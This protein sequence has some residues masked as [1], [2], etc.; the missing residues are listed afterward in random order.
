MIFQFSTEGDARWKI[1]NTISKLTEKKRK[2]NRLYYVTTRDVPNADVITEELSETY[3]KG[4]VIFP[5]KW[6]VSNAVQNQGTIN[7]YN[8]FVDS[9]YHEFNKPGTSFIVSNLD[10]DSRLFVFLRQQIEDQKDELKL[11]EV[12]ADTLILFALEDTDPDENRFKTKEQ[13]FDSVKNYVNF[14]L[15]NLDETLEHQLIALTRKPRKVHLHPKKGYCLPYETRLEI[16][17]RNLQDQN[18]IEDF[19]KETEAKIRKYLKD[20]DVTVKNLT[21]LINDTIHNIYYQQGL[22]FSNFIING[23]SKDVIEK[24]LQ[25]VIS[26][27]VDE[28]GVVTHNKEK[29]KTVLLMAIRDIVYNGTP[30]QTH[31]LKSLSNTYMMMFLLQWDPKLAIYFQALASKLTVFVCT[32][33]IIPAFSEYYLQSENKRHWNLLKGARKAGIRLYIDDSILNELTHHFKMLKYK[34]LNYFDSTEAVYLS[35]ENEILFIDEIMIRA[36]FYAKMRGSV[37]TYDDFIM[38]FLNPNLKTPRE[39]L[40]GYLKSEFGMEYLTNEAIG[41]NISEEEK[42]QLLNILKEKKDINKAKTDVNLILT[43]YKLREKKNEINSLGIFGYKTWWLSKDTSTYRAVIA[44]FGEEKYPV[45]CYIRPDF[46]YNYM[47]FM[48][49]KEEI[50][51][52]YQKIFPTLL[53]VNLSFHLPKDVTEVIQSSVAAHKDKS[54]AQVQRI[55]RQLS[56]KLKSDPALRNKRAVTLFLDDELNK[57]KSVA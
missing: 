33:I 5:L 43:I 57:L 23:E 40:L 39:D 14:D 54:P 55:L 7:A 29:I 18:L 37:R 21:G 9:Y 26:K 31:Y 48:P 28:S 6:F 56:D 17:A 45:S 2:F 46:I 22:E 51:D 42:L 12:L 20:V 8:T 36:Y 49:N 50:D 38:N 25:E 11:D 52:A 47:T 3:S 30:Q 1:I 35:D 16:Q 13:I 4:I 34:Y 44:A 10:T 53:G 32:S 24:D 19:Q 41:I 27:V 15:K